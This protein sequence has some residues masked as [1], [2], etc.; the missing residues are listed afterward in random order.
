MSATDGRRGWRNVA[1][2]HFVTLLVAVAAVVL[3][4][5]LSA[6]ATH[7]VGSGSRPHL[8]TPTVASVLRSLTPRERRYVLEV[9][10]LGPLQLWAAYGTSPAPPTTTSRLVASAILPAC[11]PGP[12]WRTSGK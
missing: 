12:C 1:S 4:I 7:A 8:R 9:A 2:R 11:G 6:S 5:A 10:S 3:V